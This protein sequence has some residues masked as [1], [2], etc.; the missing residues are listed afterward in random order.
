MVWASSRKQVAQA[1]LTAH[2]T[3]QSCSLLDLVTA[4]STFT[5]R[6]A[7]AYTMY[8]NMQQLKANRIALPD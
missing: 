6:T 4:L 5:K 8:S 3:D 7:C 1:S 2:L